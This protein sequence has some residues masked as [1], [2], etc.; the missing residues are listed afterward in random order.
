[1]QPLWRVQPQNGALDKCVV[2]VVEMA[3]QPKSAVKSW[4]SLRVKLARVT[5]FQQEEQEVFVCDATCKSLGESGEG[6][7]SVLSWQTGHL[8]VVCDYRASCNIL[9]HLPALPDFLF[10]FSFLCLADHELDCPPCKVVTS[11]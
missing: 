2:F 11:G 10:L 3:I 9:I 7:C 6:G 8:P 5:G 1:M 4:L